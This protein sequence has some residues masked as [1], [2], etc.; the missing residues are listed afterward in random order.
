MISLVRRTVTMIYAQWAGYNGRM[1]RERT[2]KLDGR[3]LRWIESGHEGSGRV[4][5]WAHAFPLSAEMW[6]PQLEAVPHGWRYLAPD[7]AGFG[8]TDDTEGTASIDDFAQDLGALADHLG[9]DRFVLGGLSMGGYSV[10]AAVRRFAPRLAGIVLADTKAGADS[11]AAREGRQKMLG[12]VASDGVSAVADEMLPKLL[13]ATA[14]RDDAG[15]VARVRALIEANSARGVARAVERLRDRPDSTAL[16]ARMGMPALVL[17][18][19]E[20]GVTPPAEAHAMAAALP[21]ATLQVI[22]RAGHLANLEAPAAFN[23]AV[24]AWLEER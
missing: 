16:L 11:A 9:L 22:P 10:F 13:G 19:E 20:D 6:R 17:V 3:R 21:K 4:A 23:E 24:A 15:L 14:Q 18:G 5:L 7:L 1:I 8:G 2:A 12:L